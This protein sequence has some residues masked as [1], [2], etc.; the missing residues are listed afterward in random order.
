[1]GDV[2]LPG[3][4]LPVSEGHATASVQRPP[5]G[6]APGVQPPPLGVA[7]RPCML[8]AEQFYIWQQSLKRG[9]K[10][11]GSDASSSSRRRKKEKKANKRKDQAKGGKIKKDKDKK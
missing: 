10:D 6:W 4:A 11:S 8:S 2:Q 1:M 9:R 5:G 7:V 3:E